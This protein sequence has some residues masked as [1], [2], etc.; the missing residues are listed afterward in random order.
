MSLNCAPIVNKVTDF[1]RAQMA[2]PGANRLGGDQAARAYVS[3]QVADAAGVLNHL[4]NSVSQLPSTVA[5]VASEGI[6]AVRKLADVTPREVLNTIAAAPRDAVN[7]S[8]IGMGFE[9]VTSNSS[10]ANKA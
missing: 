7:A 9:P 10:Q 2:I 4:G 5:N 1:V 3:G 8:R 6:N